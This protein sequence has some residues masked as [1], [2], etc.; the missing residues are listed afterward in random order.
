[1]GGKKMTKKIQSLLVVSMVLSGVIMFSNGYVNAIDEMAITEQDVT[2]LVEKAVTFLVEKGDEALALI[3]TPNGEFHKG[4]LYA[5]VYDENITI[6]AH[7][8]KPTLVGQN[9]KGKPDVKGN[10]FR[11][12]I[13]AKAL[14][15]GGWTEYFYS[16]P[17]SAGIFKKRVFSKL[18]EKNGKK[19]IV[20]VGMYGGK[21]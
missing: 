20:A 8:Y 9:F 5:F 17:D 21:L 3:G 12:E 4:E 1:M 16:K 13:V 11:D 10:K 6:I 7:P 2:G 14:N 15:G 18:A 19:Y